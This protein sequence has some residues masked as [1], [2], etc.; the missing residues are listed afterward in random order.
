MRIP[1]T[2][3]LKSEEYRNRLIVGFDAMFKIDPWIDLEHGGRTRGSVQL[4][5]ICIQYNTR[6]LG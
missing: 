4:Y 6:L 3:G 2:D 1:L 5:Y